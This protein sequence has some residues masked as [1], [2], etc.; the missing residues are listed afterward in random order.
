MYNNSSSPAYIPHEEDS[1]LDFTQNPSFPAKRPQRHFG[2]DGKR[3]TSNR[4]QPIAVCRKR[5]AKGPY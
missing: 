2:D 3:E 4:K 5:D 1:I